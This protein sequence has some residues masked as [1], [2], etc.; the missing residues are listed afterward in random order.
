[1]YVGEKIH[2]SSPRKETVHDVLGISMHM[3]PPYI[4]H[5]QDPNTTHKLGAVS[6]NHRMVGIGRDLWRSSSTLP[7]PRSGDTGMCPGGIW[8]S[9]EENSIM[10][11]LKILASWQVHYILLTKGMSNGR[12]YAH[13]QYFKVD[14]SCLIW[15]NNSFLKIGLSFE[16]LDYLRWKQ[17]CWFLLL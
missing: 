5:N 9:I 14:L 17:F 4:T 15:E 10:A 6:Q 7:S 12:G 1:M 2:W 3:Q 16:Q 11:F 8:K 13:S